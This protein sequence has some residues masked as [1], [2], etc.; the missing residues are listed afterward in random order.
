M[1]E[2]GI[3]IGATW[4]WWSSSWR[5]RIFYRLVYFSFIHSSPLLFFGYSF[6]SRSCVLAKKIHYLN[7]STSPPGSSSTSLAV[8]YEHSKGPFLTTQISWTNE[9]STA[10]RSGSYDYFKR[11][12]KGDTNTTAGKMPLPSRARVYAE[13]N[14]HKPRDYWDYESYVVE[15]G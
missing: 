3:K 11:E 10:S 7:S 5:S 6:P 1:T 15:W 8:I 9:Y 14:S 4:W 2:N 13:V 12:V